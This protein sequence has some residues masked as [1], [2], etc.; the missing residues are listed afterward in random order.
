M[1]TP[2]PFRRGRFAELPE[3]PRRP[4]G[5][6]DAD[7]TEVVIDSAPFGR[8][9]VH[10]V[11]HGPA[12]APPLLLVHGLMTSSYSWRYLLEPLGRRFRLVVPDLPGCG[13]SEPVPGRPHS[14]A[15]LGVFLGELQQHLGIVGC[16]AVG[17]S[18]GG[19]L[20]L[21][22]ALA[23]PASFGRLAVIHAPGFPEPRLRA[24]HT[25]LTLPGVRRLL[26]GLVRRDPPRWAHRNVHY[27]D[28]T[29]KSLEE[30]REYGAP[31]STVEG[32]AAF[33]RYLADSLDP[34]ELTAFVAQLRRRRDAGLGSPTPLLLVYADRDPM[35][36]PAIGP[37]LHALLP[38]AE[39]HTLR[40]TSH[41]AHVDSPDRLAP[42][43]LDFLTPP[44]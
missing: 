30:A 6:H 11:G 4:H 41:F 24:L 22:R 40:A 21:R 26:A 3:L 9:R 20:C 36:P 19:Y 15:A 5:Y 27:Y 31:L 34:A 35:V 29:L 1:D 44:G 17:N 12:D 38:D 10:V 39:Y 18:L 37:R 7:A 32:S 2:T 14:A 42:L 43:L 33:T 13:R 16:A 23:E 28:E 25:A 8:V